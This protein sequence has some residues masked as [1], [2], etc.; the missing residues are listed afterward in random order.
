MA[1]LPKEFVDEVRQRTDIVDIVSEH[2]QLRRSGRSFVGLCPFHSERT[3][4]FSVSTDRQLYHCFGCGAGGTV[5]HFVMEVEGVDFV[6]A[7]LQLA[8]R[9]SVQVPTEVEVAKSPTST[10]TKTQRMRDAHELATKLY[11]YILMNTSTGAQAL[12]YLNDRGISRQTVAEYRLGFAPQS[13]NTLLSFL[14]RRG[15]DENVI[16]EA[17]LAVQVNQRVIDRFRGRVMIPIANGQGQIVAF[18]GRTTKAGVTP[19]YLNSPETPIFQK[20][21]LLYNQYVARRAIRQTGTAVL[22]E[23]YMDV[24]AAVQA[25]V[26]NSVASLGTAFTENQ[27]EILKRWCKRVVIAYDGDEAG[28]TATVRAAQVAT[29]AGLDVQV[30]AFP[31]GVDP[32][33]FIQTRGAMEFAAFIQERTM[34]MV[35]FLFQRQR[36]TADLRTSAGQNEFVRKTLNLLQTWASPIEQEVMFKRLSQEFHLSVES[37]KEEFALIAKHSHRDHRSTRQQTQ[38]T[39]DVVPAGVL[40]KGDTTAANRLLQAALQDR[41]ALQ[42]LMEHEVTQLVTDEQTALLANLYAFHLD[43][44]NGTMADFIESLPDSHWVG[45][46]SSLLVEEAPSTEASVLEDYLRTIQLHRAEASYRKLLDSLLRAQNSGETDSVA[47]LKQEIAQMQ[48]EIQR[49]KM[50]HVRS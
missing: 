39:G 37:L 6:H 45:F 19:K 47:N 26:L 38:H 50:P 1:L 7:V 13:D 9:A 2:V 42:F 30:A 18:G 25:G 22:L 46:A 14:K 48:R 31:T 4:S 20:G 44:P 29:E 49:L 40:A 12:A 41:D 17:G 21:Q 33:E 15:F 35:E 32:D 11:N 10:L 8:E 28:R 34:T 5:I 43:Y 23:G 24:L 36:D 27:A 16:V 3:P